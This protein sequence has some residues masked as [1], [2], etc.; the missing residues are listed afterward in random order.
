[1]NILKFGFPILTAFLL[2]IFFMSL[3]D[4]REAS[5][6]QRRE[7]GNHRKDVA[8][9]GVITVLYALIAF[10]NLGVTSSPVSFAQLDEGDAVVLE[11]EKPAPLE[12][13]YVY[14]G[15]TV[16]EYSVS[17]SENGTEY[18]EIAVVDQNYAEILKWLD[19]DWDGLY[20]GP[21]QYIRLK[22][23]SGN[24]RVGELAAFSE[25]NPVSFRQSEDTAAK[26]LTDEQDTVPSDDSYMN[27]SYFDEIY[28]VRTA[29]EHLESMTPYEI[30]HP[31]LGKLIIG[32]G[33]RIFG[34]V[35]FG[36]RF[37]GTLFGV[38][39][40]PA[41]Y[42]F[43]SCMFGSTVVSACGSILLATDFM[44]FTQTRIATIDSFA[45]FFIILMY[46]FMYRY[47]T[48]GKNRNLALSGI[49]FGLGA[50]SKWTCLYAGAGL[51][52]IWLAFWGGKIISDKD[53][54]KATFSSF[55]KNCCFCLVF[56]VAIPGLIYYLSYYAYGTAKGMT[57]PG[58]LFTREYLQT[59]LDNQSF[60][61]T[62]HSGVNATHPYSSKWYQ[63][64]LDIR[65]ILYYLRYYSDGTRSSFGAFV[66]PA[67]CWGGLISILMLSF[68]AVRHRD[69][70]AAFIVLGYLAQLVP[71]IPI[72]RVLFEYHY[73][74]CTV[75]LVLAVGYLFNVMNN[76]KSGKWYVIGFASL[77]AL[78]FLLFYPVISGL[79]VDSEAASAMLGW[80]PT[81]PF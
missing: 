46:L 63:W 58:M 68:V 37:M 73:F 10:T 47:V 11:L 19:P 2:A 71:W 24:P 1:M 48:D 26:A 70:T 9:C 35:P 21:V 79:R 25:G 61:L 77:S 4:L 20:P 27:S 45:V 31:P 8:V 56:F 69:N 72:S 60:M 13:L 52:V 7:A 53:D 28:H 65:P 55:L 49:F 38:L 64:I 42:M 6:I 14:S 41:I 22:G 50:A 59:V 57:G 54:R 76:M 40:V 39:M 29:E 30:S 67:L 80:L 75:F 12:K 3:P 23:L 51:A 33:I 17:F 5:G 18:Y 78:L 36:W 43:L 34:L 15:M 81:W 32:L 74:A 16:G 62:Y 44:H 66:N